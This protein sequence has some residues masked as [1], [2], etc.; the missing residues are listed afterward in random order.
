MV[1]GVLRA[2]PWASVLCRPAHPDDRECVREARRVFQKW[3]GRMHALRPQER[4]KFQSDLVRILKEGTL[5]DTRVDKKLS[6]WG[7][8]L[9]TEWRWEVRGRAQFERIGQK[10]TFATT[11]G[12]EIAAL[13]TAAATST[14][15]HEVL[16]AWSNAT[17][18]VRR[19]RHI[20]RQCQ[21]ECL[22]IR[23]VQCKTILVRDEDHHFKALNRWA[24]WGVHRGARLACERCLPDT[25][26]CQ[27]GPRPRAHALEKRR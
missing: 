19:L 25:G 5:N 16:R 12:R 3:K 1:G 15:K 14:A 13:T 7:C 10:R 27:D 11:D 26:R 2:Q 18:D 22:L 9:S 20:G 21:D 24:P 17:I 6:R 8:A 23:C 4:R